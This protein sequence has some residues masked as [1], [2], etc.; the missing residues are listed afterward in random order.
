MSDEAELIRELRRLYD[1]YQKLNHR[2]T[3]AHQR[4]RFSPDP[5]DSQK[6]IEDEQ[7]L[8]TEIDRLM[9]RMRA[10]EGHLMAIRKRV[11]PVL[12]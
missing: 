12:H 7:K 4:Q 2:I 11:R 9:T 6:A 3:H 5:K 1:E 8:L 10:V